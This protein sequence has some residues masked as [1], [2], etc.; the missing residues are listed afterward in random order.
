M[1]DVIARLK[2]DSAEYDR[3]IG[4]SKNKLKEFEKSGNDAGKALQDFSGKL[5]LNIGKLGAMGV[6][7]GA[8]TAALKVAKDALSQS[9][10]AI[11][12]W[13]RMTSSAKGAYDMFLQSLNT[14]NWDNFFTRLNDA[15]TGARD[16]Y[17]ALDRLGSIKA[18]NQAAIAITQQ[19]I[20][21]LRLRQQNGEDVT[22]ELTAATERLAK[23]QRQEVEA[24]ITAG[25]DQMVQTLKNAGISEAM[26][27]Q[28]ADELAKGGQDVFD[29]YAQM[30]KDLEKEGTGKGKAVSKLGG[31]IKY[32]QEGTFDEANLNEE[33]KKMY[34][35]AKAITERETTLQEGIS[36]YAQAV[37]QGTAS[38]RE[39]FKNTKYG[40]SSSGGGG[41]T[42]K[43]PY[44][45]A[46]MTDEEYE[47]MVQQLISEANE[48]TNIFDTTT[49]SVVQLRDVWAE[50]MTSPTEWIDEADEGLD[51]MATQMWKNIEAAKN[52]QKD[53]DAMQASFRDQGI[54]ATI[55]AFQSLGH[56]I[57]GTEGQVISLV[58]A[59]AQ[60]VAQGVVSI[61]SMM[62]QA[63]A[64]KI[65]AQAQLEDAAAKTMNAHSW[66]PF[67]GVAM[68]VGMVATMIATIASLPKFA[69][70]GIVGG[71]DKSD[72]TLV[73]VSAGELIL[74]KAQQNNL[75]SQLQASSEKTQ[76]IKVEIENN[77]LVGTLNNADKRGAY[78]A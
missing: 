21:Q 42:N 7:I 33:Q 12:E 70:G 41:K 37:Q 16:L 1:A 27:R 61:S 73:R 30:V 63:A 20:Q 26:A 67:A 44:A 18:N 75:A 3:K 43:K 54:D 65:D 53:W 77:K 59:M 6:A 35:L 40:S 2:V 5:G 71:N 51:R 36:T 58:A 47:A 9:E 10:S 13:G 32:Y 17:D 15:I 76:I 8:T 50:I 56:A 68:A 69:T 4:Q 57:G 60:Q 31:I 25:T 19:S 62:A 29:K 38:A 55:G 72:N 11:D 14:G 66:I 45:S 78:T 52:F 64:A 24:G 28:A 74:N 23:L 39:Q 49:E 46:G 48:A 22:S 34:Q